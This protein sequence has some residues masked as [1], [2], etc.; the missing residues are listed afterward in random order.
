MAGLRRPRLRLDGHGREWG[1]D[2]RVTLLPSGLFLR[3]R[4]ERCV[5]NRS[6]VDALAVPPLARGVASSKGRGFKEPV[7]LFLRHVGLTWWFQHAV[8]D[9][10]HP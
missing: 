2:L 1:L 6:A 8:L 10:R 5:H 9:E 7:V 4:V 3:R